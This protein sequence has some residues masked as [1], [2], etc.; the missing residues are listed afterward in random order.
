ML[1]GRTIWTS[2][3]TLTENGGKPLFIADPTNNGIHR[4]FGI[5]VKRRCR[6]QIW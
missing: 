1:A 6:Y 3:A 4:L 2:L 5:E